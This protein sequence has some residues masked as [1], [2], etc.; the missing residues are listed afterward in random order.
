MHE[1]D[2][3]L[4][5]QNTKRVNTKEY[6]IWRFTGF[7]SQIAFFVSLILLSQS[8]FSKL[9]LIPILIIA[10]ILA[11]YAYVVT[12]HYHVETSFMAHEKQ[13]TLWGHAITVVGED[14][15]LLYRY[16][17]RKR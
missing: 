16:L 3:L 9:L 5:K 1:I 6:L 8:T 7:V 14:L 12:K 17:R 15:A 13:Q 4:A 2:E 10:V 11:V